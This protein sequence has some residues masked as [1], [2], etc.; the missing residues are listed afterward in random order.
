ML[1]V[2]STS[3]RE[4]VCPDAL[5]LGGLPSAHLAHLLLLFIRSALQ[6]PFLNLLASVV[7]RAGRVRVRVG[8]N[9]QE[10][11]TLVDSLP[12]DAMIAKDKQASSNPVSSSAFF[13]P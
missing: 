7:D 10:T 12:D 6:V 1:I 5:Y 4:I 9:T 2:S 13:S 3:R 8:G 11:A